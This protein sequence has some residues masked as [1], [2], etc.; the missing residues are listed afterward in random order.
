MR[1]LRF[2]SCGFTFGPK[3]SNFGFKVFKSVKG[4]ID[5]SEP[6]VGN[7]VE[8]TKWRKNRESHFLGRDF[9]IS[10]GAKKI[11]DALCK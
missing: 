5:G 1:G 10:C 2:S 7:L 11:L 6:K 9:T 3:E 8:F 4:S